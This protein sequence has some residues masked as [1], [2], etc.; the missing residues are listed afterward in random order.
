MSD[1]RKRKTSSEFARL[2]SELIEKL[3]EIDETQIPF[4]V[5]TVLDN[6]I[7]AKKVPYAV[8]YGCDNIAFCQDDFIE[9]RTR[10]YGNEQ[11]FCRDCANHCWGCGRDYSD[12][13]AYEHEDCKKMNNDEGSDENEE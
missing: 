10:D 8:C 3:E 4:A 13:M 2:K 1:D 9:L 7:A 6:I 5:L 12:V 11:M